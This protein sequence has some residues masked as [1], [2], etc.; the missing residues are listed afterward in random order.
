MFA[1]MKGIQPFLGVQTP[2]RREVVRAAL[3][4]E[5]DRAVRFAA[6]LD[7]WAGQFR[8]ER[9]TALDVL[10]ASRPRPAD[11][12]FLEG[13]LPAADRWDVLDS[14][15]PLLAGAFANAEQRRERVELWRV[16]P[17]LWTRRAAVLAQLKA[18][19]TTD[20]DLLLDTIRAVQHEREFFIQ[21]AIGWALREYAKT[22][23]V[24]VLAAAETLGL[25]GLARREAL[26]HLT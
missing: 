7:L 6:A 26:K 21:K 4:L 24:W 25:T 8:E 12:P 19:R 9:Y 20:Q 2:A 11:L 15:S 23:P 17:H 22:D 3:K 14:L 10:A 1:Y 16:S 13:L 18:K 5:P